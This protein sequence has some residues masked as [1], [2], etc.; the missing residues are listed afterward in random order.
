MNMTINRAAIAF[1]AETD[2]AAQA[3]TGTTLEGALNRLIAWCKGQGVKILIAILLLV[4][5][6]AI[7]NSI[8]R[9]LKKLSER[10]KWDK[11]LSKTL[12]A[13]F[14]VG[15]KVLI[16]LTLMSYVGID[17]SALTALLT[18]VGL[19]IGLAMQGALSNVAGGVLIIVTRPF[20]V[21]DYV[22][23]LGE[24]G[25]VEEIGLI[26]TYLRTYDNR[27]VAIPNGT[28]AN[29]TV[30]NYTKKATRRVERTYTIAYSADF[31][32]AQQAVLEVASAHD[33][34][35]KDPAPSCRISE[36]GNSAIVLSVK[37]WTKT[38]D[39]WDVYFDLN[40]QIKAKFDEL[41]I[42]IPFN[43]LDVHLD[44][45]GDVSDGAE[46]D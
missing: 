34:I 13:V 2:S 1:V 27:M 40:E 37:A 11:T 35:L 16:V 28:L 14:K 3:A 45:K 36:H 17:I 23:A 20:H 21:D 38:D 9:S 31:G 10:K 22:G 7:V 33:K 8:S 42:E 46:K 19:G 24:E 43:Q 5:C 29:S 15:M 12:I 6:F 26:Y 44:R 41:G 32:K 25:F 39:Y 4:V 18:T 30:V